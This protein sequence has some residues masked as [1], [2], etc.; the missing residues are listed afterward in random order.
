MSDLEGATGVTGFDNRKS[1]I[2]R[3]F[4]NSTV[5]QY[6]ENLSNDISAAAKG[7]VQL[8]HMK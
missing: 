8:G 6:I 1:L 4:A 7:A 3:I 5:D 2:G